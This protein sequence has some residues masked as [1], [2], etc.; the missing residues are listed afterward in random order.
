MQRIL[1]RLAVRLCF[2]LVILSYI[3]FPSAYAAELSSPWDFPPK[4]SKKIG[5]ECPAGSKLSRNLSTKG[6]YVDDAKSVVDEE[7]QA[8]YAKSVEGFRQAG[9]EVVALADKYRATGD[10]AIPGCVSGLL[11]AMANDGA[12]SGRMT[13]A[14][15]YT[16]R[17]WMLNAYSIA[18]LKV[19]AGLDKDDASRQIV[20]KWLARLAYDTAKYNDKHKR[21]HNLRYW[22]GLGVMSAGIAANNKKLFDWGVDSYKMGANDIGPDGVLSA[23]IK[24][25]DRALRY[26]AFA[27]APLVM[28]AALA[29][30]NN[31]DLYGENNNALSRL[32]SFVVA[33]VG[34]S[35]I[36]NQR[37]GIEQLGLRPDSGDL[38]WLHLYSQQFPNTS[39]ITILKRFPR[40]GNL[41][42]GGAV[43]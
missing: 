26:H 31:V 17:A 30:V 25:G 8:Q 20:P 40:K 23:E 24:R 38:A 22:A 5:S 42:L 39:Y 11:V 41:Y 34:D 27:A 14:Q 3:G 15:A 19:R 29:K 33:N 7:L 12:L 13:G 10:A 1:D 16:L 35:T 2:F 36:V 37:T 9:S 28:I 21:G 32:V 6:Y 43:P 4:A 18:W